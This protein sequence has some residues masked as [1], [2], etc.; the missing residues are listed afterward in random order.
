MTKKSVLL[1]RPQKLQQQL[2]LSDRNLRLN[3][4]P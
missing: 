2:S 3:E 1:E 4:K